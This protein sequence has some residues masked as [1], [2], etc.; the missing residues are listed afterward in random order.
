[1]S[2]IFDMVI[3]F[4]PSPNEFSQIS[5]IAQAGPALYYAWKKFT[6]I[7]TLTNSSNMNIE[8]RI[9]IYREEGGWREI[10]KIDENR[11]KNVN[12]NNFEAIADRDLILWQ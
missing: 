12:S 7:H 1:M 6:Y 10:P 11:K 5:R 9:M 8:K 2:T 4:I 3:I